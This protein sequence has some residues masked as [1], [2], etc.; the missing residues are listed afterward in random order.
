MPFGQITME[1]SEMM[2]VRKTD[3]FSY[4]ASHYGQNYGRNNC[5]CGCD[6]YRQCNDNGCHNGGIQVME[7][8]VY[9]IQEGINLVCEGL[10]DIESGKVCEGGREVSDGMYLIKEGTGF[11]NEGMRCAPCDPCGCG[12][13]N[14]RQGISEEN[15]GIRYM[16][17][18][19]CDIRKGNV[20]DGIRE[21]HEGI[22]DCENGTKCINEGIKSVY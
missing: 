13:E 17:E 4:G 7:K 8:G 14:I 19:L 16:N 5:G 11:V 18:G 15:V 20:C 9:E 21:L 12:Y 2:R 6:S 1:K 22:C 10:R 3:R